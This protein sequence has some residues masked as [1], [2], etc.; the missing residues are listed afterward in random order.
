EDIEEK[1]IKGGMETSKWDELLA[2]SKIPR[3]I[4]QDFYYYLLQTKRAFIFD[5]DRLISKTAVDEAIN[6]LKQQTNNEDFTLQTARE[7]LKLS[8]KNLVPILELLDRLGYTKR[9]E[10]LRKL[11]N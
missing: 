1:L 3:A 11:V 4:Q 9:T 6:K 7:A 8:R 10:N 5:E 2:N